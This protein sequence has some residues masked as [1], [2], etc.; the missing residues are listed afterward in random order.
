[1]TRLVLVLVLT[2]S[3]ARADADGWIDLFNG[4]DLT[5]WVVDGPAE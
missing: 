4:K 1:M 2:A 3:V 5:G